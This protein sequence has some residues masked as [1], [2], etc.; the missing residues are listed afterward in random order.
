MSLADC[1]WQYN[2][3]PSRMSSALI[4]R[5]IVEAQNF[6]E[7][8]L[9]LSVLFKKAPFCLE[10]QDGRIRGVDLYS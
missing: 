4:R 2:S 1:T 7:N 10:R 6:D 8:N 3:T 9:S 5:K